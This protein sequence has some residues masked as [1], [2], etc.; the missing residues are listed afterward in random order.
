MEH[1][2]SIR[3]VRSIQVYVKLASLIIPLTGI[4][5]LYRCTRSHKVCLFNDECLD[6]PD[7]DFLVVWMESDRC[8][9]E[10][11]PRLF[12]SAY[13][14][15]EFLFRA[16]LFVSTSHLRETQTLSPQK[17]VSIKNSNQTFKIFLSPFQFGM[18]GAPSGLLVSGGAELSRYFMFVFWLQGQSTRFG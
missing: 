15:L 3:G 12:S 13:L 17:V 10:L 11:P 5:E 14:L 6:S 2:S 18:F 16:N 1:W 8:T 7:E 9:R 4:W